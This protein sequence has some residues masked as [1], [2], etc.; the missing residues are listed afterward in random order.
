MFERPINHRLEPGDLGLHRP[1]GFAQGVLD[2]MEAAE[3]RARYQRVE[4]G[5]DPADVE[6]MKTVDVLA[7]LERFDHPR[8]IDLRRQRQLD[9]D[10]VD[11]LVGIE[12]A[13]EI[14]QLGL[15]NR[16]GEIVREAYHSGLGRGA[17][18]RA[19]I[20]RARRILADEHCRQAR[21]ASDALLELGDPCGNLIADRGRRGLAVD[22][23]RRH[24]LYVVAVRLLSAPFSNMCAIWIRMISTIGEK[25]SPPKSGMTLRIGR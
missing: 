8:R 19:D 10:P 6:R 1:F 15:R 22:Q 17:V 24:G 20:D 12:L 7:R 9:E 25:S 21:R 13:D 4:P 23:P 11:P 14:E 16:V 3:R 5:R 2:Q 18:L